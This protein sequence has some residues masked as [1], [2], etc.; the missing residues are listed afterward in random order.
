MSKNP[1]HYHRPFIDRNGVVFPCCF[2]N[3]NPQAAIGHIADSDIKSKMENYSIDCKCAYANFRPKNERDEMST[4]YFQC[5]LK[6]H[7]QCA[8][9][10]VGAP[11]KKEDIEVDYD[12]ALRFAK[13][14]QPKII[15][16]E[17]GEIPIL[18]KAI[19]FAKKIKEDMPSTTLR[20]I[21]NGCYNQRKAVTIASIFDEITISFMGFSPMVY[22]AETGLN[23]ENT[24]LFSRIAHESDVFVR[25]RF[26]C[27]PMTLPDIGLFL[28]WAT[29]FKNARPHIDDCQVA[30]FLE[31]SCHSSYW[32][33]IITRC[34][35]LFLKTL[36]RL[37]KTMQENNI[38]LNIHPKAA[39]TLFFNA[40]LRDKLKLNNVVFV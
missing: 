27:T 32:S 31:L 37:N 15:S 12:H 22:F 28:E 8:V 29:T 4:L 16:L 38:I 17:G 6:C 3:R 10:Y 35:E 40:A 18:P 13:D 7:G 30:E 36:V 2:L 21:T 39:K 19:E 20:L 5:S 11:H 23:V 26:I 25:F 14:M 24:K 33:D 34:R 1:C 9:C